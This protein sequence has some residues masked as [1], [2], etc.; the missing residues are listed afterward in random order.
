M[1]A[2]ELLEAGLSTQ[3]APS[4]GK[5]PAAD[6]GLTALGPQGK[7]SRIASAKLADTLP[8]ALQAKA[9]G[10]APDKE[11]R[12]KKSKLLR[13]AADRKTK[14]K[15]QVKGG[16]E[17]KG[18]VLQGAGRQRLKNKA[19]EE[20]STR[21]ERKADQA[22]PSAAKPPPQRAEQSDQPALSSKVAQRD[23]PFCYKGGVMGYKVPP[24]AGPPPDLRAFKYAR[25]WKVA[26]D[27]AGVATPSLSLQMLG[28]P[29]RHVW[30][31]DND[32]SCQR[33]LREHFHGQALGDAKSM[34]LKQQEPPDIYFAT[35]PCQSY[36]VLGSGD[37]EA[38]ARGVL[39]FHPLKVL[40]Q[41]RPSLAF[42]ENVATLL[43]STRSPSSALCAL[44]KT[45]ATAQ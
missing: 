23:K 41:H 19:Q 44:R 12:E 39:L 29:F 3:P 28:V 25:S 37:G 30:L 42:V 32:A 15:A 2:L 40:R 27:F 4:R 13:G 17:S 14:G 22:A 1:E 9:K 26:V 34:D 33:M 11:G 38:D 7:N 16:R 21:R 20:M 45:S 43:T 35:P 24:E 6:A 8:G 10:K 36:S 31:S 5:R 18:K